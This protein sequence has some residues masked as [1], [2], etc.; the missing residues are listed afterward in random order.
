MDRLVTPPAR[1]LSPR[2]EQ[3]T[4]F[5]GPLPIQGTNPGNEV[6]EQALSGCL[7]FSPQKSGN[8][9]WNVNGLPERNFL[10]SGKRDFLKGRPKFPNRISEWKMCA[11]FASLY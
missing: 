5:P 6:G 9:G 4:S 3:A 2:C 8:F 11:L 1:G 10:F 7:P